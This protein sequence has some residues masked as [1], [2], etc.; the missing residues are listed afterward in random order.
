MSEVISHETRFLLF[1][2]EGSSPSGK[3][4]RWSVRS[5]SGGDTLGCIGW[6]GPWRCYTYDPHEGTTYNDGC[7]RDIAGF[8]A[9]E[10]V[11]VRQHAAKRAEGEE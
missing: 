6:Y 3:T 4:G 9:K 11:A 8:M 10:T 5:R 7:L 2:S 1:V